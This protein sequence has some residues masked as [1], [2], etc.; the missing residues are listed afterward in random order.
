MAHSFI[1]TDRRVASTRVK[2]TAKKVDTSNITPEGV[3]DRLYAQFPTDMAR[4]AE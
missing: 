3:V 4:L 1:L 2:K